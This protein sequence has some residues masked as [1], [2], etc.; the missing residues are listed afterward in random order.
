MPKGA[1][2]CLFS[3][4]AV[5]LSAVHSPTHHTVRQKIIELGKNWQSVLNTCRLPENFLSNTADICG[6]SS[7]VMF[8]C[9]VWEK[10]RVLGLLYKQTQVDPMNRVPTNKRR[11]CRL[12]AEGRVIYC[13]SRLYHPSFRE[14]LGRGAR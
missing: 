9:L 5:C 6:G 11:G 4:C 7:S 12:M 3:L 8:S 14:V 10:W 2:L 1:G 13:R